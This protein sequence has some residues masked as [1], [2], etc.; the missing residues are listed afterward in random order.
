MEVV[1]QLPNT[2]AM[3]EFSPD[4]KWIL[5][6]EFAGSPSRAVGIFSV[7]SK[8]GEPRQ[9]YTTGTIDE[10]HCS[11]SAKGA[12]VMRETNDKNEFVFFTLDPV[13]GMQ[14]EVARS[15]WKPTILGDWSISPDGSLVASANHDP[16]NPGIQLISLS[17]HPSIPPSMIPVHGFG[18]VRGVNWS[19][20]AGGF[21]VETKTS[22]S[23]DL[24]YV[25]KAGHIKLLRQSPIAI[26][27]VP[28][29]DG[30]KL[31]FPGL[32][33]ASNVWAGPASLP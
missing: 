4:G 18:V 1:A 3:A 11:T 15:S 20:N 13:K 24:L 21:F 8:G 31:A 2:A 33:I 16:E 17:S 30:K 23:Y 12:C 28:S 14:Q 29:R 5:F 9:L 25:D 26:W 6:T 22:A 19:S 32:T 27:G 7:P 10:F